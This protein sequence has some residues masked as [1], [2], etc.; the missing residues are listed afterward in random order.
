[1]QPCLLVSLT[2]GLSLEIN[3]YV[4]DIDSFSG[5]IPSYLFLSVGREW[6]KSQT[7]FTKYIMNGNWSR[8]RNN[9]SQYVKRD[10]DIEQEFERKSRKKG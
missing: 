4:L 1:M 7:C 9:T 2:I 5:N 8:T 6:V 10:E 3:S